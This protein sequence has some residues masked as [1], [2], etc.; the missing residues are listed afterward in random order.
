MSFPNNNN[1]YSSDNDVCPNCGAVKVFSALTCPSCGMDY[2]EATIR[3]A[4]KA[5]AKAAN[6]TSNAFDPNA[7][8]SKYKSDLEKK[9]QPEASSIT[10]GIAPL[11]EIA[12]LNTPANDAPVDPIAKKLSELSAQNGGMYGERKYR[13]TNGS[14]A[15]EEPAQGEDKGWQSFQGTGVPGTGQVGLGNKYGNPQSG[16]PSSS[17]IPGSPYGG[18]TRQFSNTV[19]NRYEAYKNDLE[20]RGS[21]DQF[22]TPYSRGAYNVTP[23]KKKSTFVKIFPFLI[24]LAL[25]G[26]GI[27]VYFYIDSYNCNDKGVRYTQGKFINKSGNEYTPNYYTPST[28]SYINEWAEIRVDYEESQGAL[29][30]NSFMNAFLDAETKEKFDV[31]LMMM[32]GESTGVMIFTFK[33]GQ[34][35]MSEEE[36]FDDEAARNAVLSD[37]RFSDYSPE[38]DMLLG[39]NLYKCISL[40]LINNGENVKCFYCIRRI[41]NRIVCVIIYDD[42]KSSQLGTIKNMFK[43]WN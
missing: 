38:P 17:G 20:S 42:P 14:E 15:K 19:S 21:S 40:N 7:S 12:E 2:A 26:I 25:I 35:G 30:L 34:F 6:T 5:A 32:T 9:D 10:D 39:S 4:E 13:N 29:I 18:S 36:F 8:F 27:G 33:N 11:S 31:N 41:G 37:S 3:Q 24:V 43:R 28:G 16:T 22:S 1:G 23:E